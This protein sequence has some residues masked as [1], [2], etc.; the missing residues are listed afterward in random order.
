MCVYV[1]VCVCVCVCVQSS[2]TCTHTHTLGSK[3]QN[4]IKVDRLSRFVIL[5]LT[6]AAGGHQSWF[7]TQP[8]TFGWTHKGYFHPEAVIIPCGRRLLYLKSNKTG[9]IQS[10]QFRLRS[11]LY[12]LIIVDSP[13]VVLHDVDFTEV[14][15]LDYSYYETLMN[16]VRPKFP[17]QI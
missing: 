10:P 14:S 3:Y 11:I 15:T 9:T 12:Q 1:C 4:Q 8:T 7:Q 6:L 17:M 5:N 16:I 2:P 13:V